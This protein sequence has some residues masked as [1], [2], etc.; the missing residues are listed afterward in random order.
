[1]KKHYEVELAGELCGHKHRTITAADR[2]LHRI[3]DN[4][5]ISAA[6]ILEKREVKAKHTPGK[7]YFETDGEGTPAQHHDRYIVA[8]NGGGRVCTMHP[9]NDGGRSA[10][11]ANARLIAAAPELLAA[12]E[13]LLETCELNLDEMEPETVQVIESAHATIQKATGEA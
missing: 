6:R 12:L 1:M 2:C 7:W 13:A 10:M 5:D 8:E 4:G 11:D 3:A 9:P